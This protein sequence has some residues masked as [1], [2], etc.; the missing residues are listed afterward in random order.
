MNTIPTGTAAQINLGHAALL[1]LLEQELR[2]M[3]A[4]RAEAQRLTLLGY[5]AGSTV[6]DS[7]LATAV[8]RRNR[9]RLVEPIHRDS[10]I[11]AALL[12]IGAWREE[13]ALADE[14]TF[15]ARA[16]TSA[17]AHRQRMRAILSQA[18]ARARDRRE[19]ACTPG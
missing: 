17:Q 1:D 10:D 14:E 5:S 9:A 11:P 12:A 2:Q 18:E 6:T 16:I 19:D 7:M 4:E 8:R 15:E 3:E 13:L